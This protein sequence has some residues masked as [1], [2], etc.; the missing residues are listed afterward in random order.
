MKSAYSSSTLSMSLLKMPSW[1]LAEDD[2][3]DG[4]GMGKLGMSLGG[5]GCCSNSHIHFCGI[6]YNFFC[7]RF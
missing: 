2:A 6:P 3:G 7:P 4:P 1:G 5:G